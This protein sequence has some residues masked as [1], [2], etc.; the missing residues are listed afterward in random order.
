VVD[1]HRTHNFGKFALFALFVHIRARSGIALDCVPPA[2]QD[3]TVCEQRE[4]NRRNVGSGQQKKSDTRQKS[5][6][7][8]TL[9]DGRKTCRFKPSQLIDI[10]CWYCYRKISTC[11]THT[12]RRRLNALIVENGSQAHVTRLR[13]HDWLVVVVPSKRLFQSLLRIPP[14]VCKQPTQACMTDSA[15]NPVT[16]TTATPRA[17]APGSSATAPGSMDTK[18]SN[19][20][21]TTEAASGSSNAAICS[22]ANQPIAKTPQPGS[23][24]GKVL[25]GKV[26]AKYGGAAQSN[27]LE[28]GKGARSSNEYAVTAT[29]G[30][31]AAGGRSNAAAIP[32]K[33]SSWA[34]DQDEE[35]RLAAA[36]APTSVSNPAARCRA[37]GPAITNAA[38]NK[39]GTHAK[40]TVEQAGANG[41]SAV[42]KAGTHVKAAVGNAGATGKSAVSDGKAGGNGNGHNVGAHA[43]A[44]ANAGADG[45]GN[46]VIG[47]ADAHANAKADVRAKNHGTNHANRKGKSNKGINA[48]ESGSGGG[49]GESGSNAVEVLTDEKR[50]GESESGPGYVLWSDESLDVVTQYLWKQSPIKTLLRPRYDSNTCEQVKGQY[51]TVLFPRV[52]AEIAR[53]IV[54]FNNAAVRKKGQP[55]RLVVTKIM[56]LPLDDRDQ[57]DHSTQY[58]DSI[59]L[60]LPMRMPWKPMKKHLEDFFDRIRGKGLVEPHQIQIDIP[61]TSDGLH[62]RRQCTIRFETKERAER[63]KAKNP[64]ARVKL[65]GRVSERH[66]PL[67]RYLLHNYTWPL[68]IPI[69]DNDPDL[70]AQ[71]NDVGVYPQ[72]PVSH[73]ICCDWDRKRVNRDH[74]NN[75]NNRNNRHTSRKNVAATSSNNTATAAAKSSSSPSS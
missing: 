56:S 65:S 18:H 36:F 2:T 27:G 35:E 24:N 16:G 19:S 31:A 32:N 42:N 3:R 17:T 64:E 14:S 6:K 21:A 39:A 60:R 12:A 57:P 9:S 30:S 47:D 75:R 67:V 29:K 41:T 45:A 34:D 13:F 4:S 20:S 50:V 23:V 7:L 53:S 66:L 40:S 58:P 52:A 8:V 25:D 46:A 72:I 15:P 63:I 5:E 68:D 38:V 43:N 55:Q 73:F 37:D 71:P 69:L 44:G 51:V 49:G 48:V 10:R 54:S 59:F 62:H 11:Q 33:S 61:L 1:H 74:R 26:A 28:G 22:S 70:D